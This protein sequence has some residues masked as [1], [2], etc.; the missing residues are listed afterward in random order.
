MPINIYIYILMFK[1]IY[2]THILLKIIIII[3][4]RRLAF[5]KNSKQYIFIIHFK[6]K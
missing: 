4:E 1:R 6:K 5:I 3:Y 2:Y